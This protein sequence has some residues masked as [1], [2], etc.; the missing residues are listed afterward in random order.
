[1]P[2]HDGRIGRRIPRTKGR[3]HQPPDAEQFVAAFNKE[4][5][6]EKS[7]W[8]VS[9]NAG[10]KAVT[11]WVKDGGSATVAGEDFMKAVWSLWFG[12]NDQPSMGDSLMSELK[13]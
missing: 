6:K 9:Y 11:L 8:V 7:S 3:K 5:V 13:K 4:E 1:M 12:K 2:A 10:S